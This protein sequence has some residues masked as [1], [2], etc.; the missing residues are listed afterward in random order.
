MLLGTL[1]RLLRPPR[2]AKARALLLL[3]IA[4][5]ALSAGIFPRAALPALAAAATLLAAAFGYFYARI[6]AS[7]PLLNGNLYT[8]DIAQPVAIDRDAAGVPAVSGASRADV[9]FGLGFLHAQ[10]RFFQMDMSRRAAA[11]ELAEL[12]GKVFAAADR[13]AR[14]HQFRK[15]AET[16]AASLQGEERALLDSYTDG[17]RC[18]L[19]T[20]R[21]PPFEYALLRAQPAAWRPEDTLLVVFNMYRLLQDER[22]AQDFNLHLLY[23]ALPRAVADFLA[24]EGSHDWDAPLAG[25]PEP[26]AAV[27]G[28]EL[29]DFRCT[30]V[31]RVAPTLQAP[32]RVGGSNVW[33]VAASHSGIGRALVA[34]DMHLGLAMPAVF[35][36]ATLQIAGCPHGGMLSG[37]TLPGFPFLLAG[38]NGAVAW[39]LA[40]AATDAVD[41]IRLAPE[42]AAQVETVRE[43]IRVRGGADEVL[44]IRR[45]PWGPVVRR[46]R[47]GTEFVHSWIAHDPRSVDL[48]WRALETATTAGAAMQAANRIGAPTLA[49]VVCDRKGNAGWTLAGPLRQPAA[50]AKGCAPLSSQMPVGGRP[51][52]APE[53]YPRLGSPALSHVWA[54]NAR[55][56]I[57][58]EAGAL[59]GGGF[60][61][62]GARAMQI[63]DDLLAAGQGGEAAMLRLQRD[64]RALFLARWHAL[65]LGVLES[66]ALRDDSRVTEARTVLKAWDG[67]AST[68]SRAYPLVRHFRDCVE[69]LVFEPF[70]AMV[71]ARHGQFDLQSTGDQREAPLWRLVGERPPHL[72]PPWF[73]NWTDLLTAAARDVISAKRLRRWGGENRLAM[74]HPLSAFMPL[75]S[76]LLDAP[77]APQAGDMNMPLACTAQ[78]GPVFRF[79]ISPG[80]EDA[81]LLQMAGGQAGNPLA[82]YYLAGHADWLDGKPAPLLPGPV[83]YRLTLAPTKPRS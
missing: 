59:L 39:G 41:L 51:W 79:A 21:A 28:P 78:H 67:H 58:G 7:R 38:S 35:Y 73:A 31:N 80:R 49:L 47:D 45:T 66:P 3:A 53:N 77:D 52:V 46:T 48:G 8:D 36:R 15:R 25:E 71:R 5:L 63:R 70:V 40:N 82:P 1:G 69:D 32:V 64:D 33:A 29:L 10:E 24:P 55:S 37:I 11:G 65:L 68:E 19:R 4:L 22:G 27:P 75:L 42:D 60:H 72:L 20:L 26:D 83:R 50:R 2:S 54:A 81:A 9:A 14:L 13:I 57:G 56:I 6:G 18:G 12:F 43:T 17:V 62:L 34:N 74:H 76:R 16:V 23:D 44:D 61:V 30:H